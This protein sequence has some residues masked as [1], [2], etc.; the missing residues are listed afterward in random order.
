MQPVAFGPPAVTFER[1]L[2]FISMPK[3]S[4][5]HSPL[6]AISFG[7][8]SSFP[9]SLYPCCAKSPTQGNYDCQRGAL[10]K[11]HAAKDFDFSSAP[12]RRSRFWE[13]EREILVTSAAVGAPRASHR[14]IIEPN[15][16]MSII[17]IVMQREALAG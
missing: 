6:D 5:R 9:L 3:K 17:I 15:V 12:A 14:H 13:S 16:C 2:E 1:R 10:E 7:S 8:V 11:S 4:N